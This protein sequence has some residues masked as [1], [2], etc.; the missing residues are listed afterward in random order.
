ML[1]NDQCEIIFPTATLG[2]AEAASIYRNMVLKTL[3][4]KKKFIANYLGVNN[5]RVKKIMSELAEKG[6]EKY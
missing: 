2:V 6:F 4:S 5:V 3:I 1:E